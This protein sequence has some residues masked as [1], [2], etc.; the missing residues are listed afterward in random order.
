[1]LS[2]WKRLL[3]G[4]ADGVPNTA[5][6][7]RLGPLDNQDPQPIRIQV[8]QPTQPISSSQV[9]KKTSK[10]SNLNS[11]NAATAANHISG[12]GTWTTSVSNLAANQSSCK[13]VS[14]A[15]HMSE[16]AACTAEYQDSSQNR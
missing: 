8:Q 6:V 5:D 9:K 11:S 7:T 15:Q 13:T 12:Q 10:T 16:K 14:T 4:Q 1:M 3:G 2:A